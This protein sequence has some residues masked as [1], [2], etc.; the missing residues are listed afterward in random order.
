MAQIFQ[1]YLAFARPLTT[2]D[3]H[4]MPEF[5]LGPEHLDSG[6]LAAYAR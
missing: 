6:P 1:Q 4:G 5:G 3:N 2:V